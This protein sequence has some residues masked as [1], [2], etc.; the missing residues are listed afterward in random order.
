MNNLSKSIREIL[1]RAGAGF[2]AAQQGEYLHGWLPAMAERPASP[3][4]L[5]NDTVRPPK[6]SRTVSPEHAGCA[7]A[8]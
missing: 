4:S 3:L 1:R 8:H 6:D 2:A 7:G 5:L